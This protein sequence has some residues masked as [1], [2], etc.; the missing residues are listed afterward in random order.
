MQLYLS[1][2][3]TAI[4]WHRQGVASSGFDLLFL[5]FYTLVLLLVG[6]WC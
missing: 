4:D 5:G 2:S 1:G 6:F 3:I